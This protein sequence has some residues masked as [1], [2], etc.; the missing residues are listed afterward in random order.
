[1]KFILWD[2][3]SLLSL[4]L[5]LLSSN[6]YKVRHINSL[7]WKFYPLELYL[8][9]RRSNISRF[10]MRCLMHDSLISLI[11]VLVNRGIIEPVQRPRRVTSVIWTLDWQEC[12]TSLIDQNEN[13]LGT[14]E[15]TEFPW[16][17]IYC[18]I[19]KLI[20]CIV[21]VNVSFSLS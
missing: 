10:I 4:S 8:A 14:W 12:E 11:E 16:T 17:H 19:A 1:M 6:P 21:K 18:F 9:Q 2:S 15:R 3:F 13:S 20:Y 5:S 7:S